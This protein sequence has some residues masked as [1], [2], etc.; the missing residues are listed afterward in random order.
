[1]TF[2]DYRASLADTITLRW[3]DFDRRHPEVY[4][5][6]V[7][8]ALDAYASGERYL[9]MKWIFEVIRRTVRRDED[10]PV[11]LNNDYSAVV[12]RKLVA[13][14]PE[15]APLFHTRRRRSG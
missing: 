8:T 10:E 2:E 3:E 13:E 15:L 1:M 14:H 5:Q 7:A 6:I 11:A 12:T 4:R 9:S